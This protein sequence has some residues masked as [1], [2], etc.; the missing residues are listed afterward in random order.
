MGPVTMV[1][2]LK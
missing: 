1:I 2:L